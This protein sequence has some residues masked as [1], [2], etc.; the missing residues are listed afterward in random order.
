[1]AGKRPKGV[2]GVG[3]ACFASAAT[4]RTEHRP[5]STDYPDSVVRR[6]SFEAGGG[7][8][9]RIS[10]LTTPRETPA[11]VKVVVITGSPSWAEYWA[12]LMAAL[13]QDW[14]MTVVDRPGFAGSEPVEP[15]F[16]L[17][18]QAVALAPA[19]TAAPGQKLL[20]LGQSYGAAIATLIAHNLTPQARPATRLSAMLDRLG[21]RKAR[22]EPHPVCGLVLLS[23]FFGETGPT[24]R[25]LV[26]AGGRMLNLIP[27][28]LRNAVLEV[29]RQPPQ[30]AAVREALAALT[31]PVHLIHGDADDF[32]PLTAAERL[33]AEI[34]RAE[35]MR[36]QTV[37]GGDHFLN[38]RPPAE[39]MAILE[40]CLPPATAVAARRPVT[41]PSWLRRL[42]PDPG[43]AQTA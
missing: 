4:R 39:I 16:D 40:A 24:S 8:G 11:K 26:D 30:L 19:V 18:T 15:V 31:I 6:I 2:L 12:P 13:P 36:L 5:T 41:V 23:G 32:A 28:D 35:P 17:A 38:D 25:W 20:L 33:A 43:M 3:L 1:V 29:G 42:T 27:R 9:W 34:V 37:A 21:L 14:E 10:A 22:P 7:H